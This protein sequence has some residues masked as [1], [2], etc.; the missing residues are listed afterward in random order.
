VSINNYGL[1]QSEISPINR[2]ATQDKLS[3]QSKGLTPRAYLESR[4]RSIP[5]FDDYEEVQDPSEISRAAAEQHPGKIN[6]KISNREKQRFYDERSPQ[7]EQESFED[8]NGDF[9]R[10]RQDLARLS[11]KTSTM[12][13]NGNL[14]KSNYSNDYSTFKVSFMR[15]ESKILRNSPSPKE[16]LPSILDV[17]KKKRITQLKNK[18]D[19]ITGKEKLHVAPHTTK[20]KGEKSNG[21]SSWFDEGSKFDKIGSRIKDSHATNKTSMESVVENTSKVVENA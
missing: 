11:R 2:R 19:L 8:K 10:N 12:L 18:F 1:N 20:A 21:Q 16:K 3:H 15:T 14:D 9:D 4:S 13:T 6:K 5:M 7:Q 17:P